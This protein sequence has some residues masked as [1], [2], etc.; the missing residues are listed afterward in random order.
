MVQHGQEKVNFDDVSNEIFDMCRPNE[1]D[2]IE[3][4]IILHLLKSHLNFLPAGRNHF[5]NLKK[6]HVQ[7]F[8]SIWSG[9]RGD[10]HFI[11]SQ[12]ILVIWKS[13]NDFRRSQW[14]RCMILNQ[15]VSILAMNNFKFIFLKISWLPFYFHIKY[16]SSK[17]VFFSFMI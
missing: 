17:I 8:D 6:N 2:R 15:T 10:Q 16:F 14:R 9:S 7:R 5:S 1:P 3:I 12:W 11:W 13:G 4:L